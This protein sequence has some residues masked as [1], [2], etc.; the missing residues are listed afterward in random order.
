MIWSQTSNINTN[1]CYFHVNNALDKPLRFTW[2]GSIQ[3]GLQIRDQTPSTATTVESENIGWGGA[4]TTYRLK[5]Q[6]IRQDGTFHDITTY[7]INRGT[8][9]LTPC[10]A[11]TLIFFGQYESPSTFRFMVRLFYGAQTEYVE[12]QITSVH[13]SHWMCERVEDCPQ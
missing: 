10:G 13:L 8:P 7:I 6:R 3:G 4:D 5:I 9:P 12:H 1:Y 2:T 11:I